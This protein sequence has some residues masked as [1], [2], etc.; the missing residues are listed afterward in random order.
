MEKNEEFVEIAQ[1]SLEALSG[2]VVYSTIL[3]FYLDQLS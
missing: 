1:K 2:C 3:S